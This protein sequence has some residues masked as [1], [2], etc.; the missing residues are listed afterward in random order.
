MKDICRMMGGFYQKKIYFEGKK[1]WRTALNLVY[2]D[3]NHPEKT[4]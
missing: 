1:I 3:T 4:A 2:Q